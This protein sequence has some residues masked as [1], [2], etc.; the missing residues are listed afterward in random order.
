LGGALPGDPKTRDA[1]DD[2]R[3]N[4]RIAV[5][6]RLSFLT[7]AIPYAMVT[8]LW[9]PV[10][11]GLG[12]PIGALHFCAVALLFGNSASLFMNTFFGHG[13]AAMFVMASVLAVLRRWPVRVALFLGLAILCD[14]GAILVAAP[15]LLVIRVNR[16]ISWSRYLGRMAVGATVPAIAWIG[17]HTY[18]FGGPFSLA[19]KYQNPDFVDIA[20][21]TPNLW[22]VFRLVPE[23][24]SFGKLLVSPER[25]LALTQGWILVSLVGAAIVLFRPSRSRLP[26]ALRTFTRSMTLFAATSLFF[27][28]WMNACFGGWHGGMTPGPRYL[29]PILP[30]FALIGAVSWAHSPSW[31]RQAMFIG[32]GLS[33]ILFVLVESTTPLAPV[34]QSLFG[35]YLIEVTSD[36]GP[37]L[38]RALVLSLGFAWAGTRALRQIRGADRPRSQGRRAV[39][40]GETRPPRLP[41]PDRRQ[42]E[43]PPVAVVEQP[44]VRTASGSRS[45]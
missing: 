14:Y 5:L 3:V 41:D 18:C 13:M 36:Q 22:G 2:A 38:A 30:V 11:G 43:A 37:T 12:L 31:V 45:D 42:R 16:S 21:D 20:R 25:G 7:Q 19:T 32:L 9:M 33:V 34:D 23:A 8:L 24:S 10:L 17:Y 35:F 39:A 4:G 15:L 6:H 26:D 29:S 27:L 28:L 40:L 44:S 1:Q